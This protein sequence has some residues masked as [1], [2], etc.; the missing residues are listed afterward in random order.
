[1]R[2]YALVCYLC[3]TCVLLLCGTRRHALVC[4]IYA[5]LVFYCCV[6]PDVLWS[7]LFMRD[8]CFIA[9]WDQMCSG[10]DCLCKTCV[11]SHCGMRRHVLVCLFMQDLCFIAVWDQM[12][13][14]LDCEC[15]TCVLSHCGMRRHVLVCLFMQDLCFIAVCCIRGSAFETVSCI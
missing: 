13:S 6:G 4:V 1:M 10:L 11:L 8:L 7:G 5:R 3:K 2:R 12:C 15:K 14:D 9:V